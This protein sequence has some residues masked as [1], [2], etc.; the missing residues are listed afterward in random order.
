MVRVVDVPDGRTIIVS[1]NG[2]SS[3]VTLGG[4]SFE[5]DEAADAAA[6]LKRLVLGQWVL[7]E[8]GGMVYRSPDALFVN[9]EMARHAW[10]GIPGFVYLG[11][12]DPGPAKARPRAAAE[13]P[14]AAMAT[15]PLPKVSQ[16]T[17]KRPHAVPNLPKRQ[18]G[19]AKQQPG[20]G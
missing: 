2:R 6:Y 19:V 7:V 4:V 20:R 17:L 14:Q 5:G 16:Q 13:M 12:V 18:G 10:R 11:T 9:N 1:D 8:T 3:T 15:A